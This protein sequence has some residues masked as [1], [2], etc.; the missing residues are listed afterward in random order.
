MNRRVFLLIVLALI[1]TACGPAGRERPR[2]P[3][4]ANLLASVGQST[5]G[6]SLT[7]ID[8]ATWAVRHTVALP[9]SKVRQLSRDPLGRI[10][11]GFYGTSTLIDNRVQVYSSDG[12]LLHELQPC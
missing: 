3:A 11:V 10:W 7:L 1:L 9:R 4:G 6:Q 2:S 12:D 5:A 8:P